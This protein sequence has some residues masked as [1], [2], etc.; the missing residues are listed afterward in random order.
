M[1]SQSPSWPIGEH[2]VFI[3]RNARFLL[4]GGGMRANDTLSSVQRGGWTLLTVCGQV[5]ISSKAQQNLNDEKFTLKEM[6]RFTKNKRS[7]SPRWLQY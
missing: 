4:S 5:F 1:A 6:C 2:H 7:C 3:E